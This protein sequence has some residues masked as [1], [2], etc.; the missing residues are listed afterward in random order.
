MHSSLATGSPEAG[1]PARLTSRHDWQATTEDGFSPGFRARFDQLI[2]GQA[3][4][5]HGVVIVQRGRRV[6]EKLTTAMTWSGTRTGDRTTHA[7]A[8]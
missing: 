6:F 5:I 1:E 2:A 7:L 4:N 8:F 3:G